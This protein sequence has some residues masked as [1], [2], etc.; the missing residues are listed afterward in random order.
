MHL[1]LSDTHIG[2]RRTDRHMDRLLEILAEHADPATTLVL[3]GDVFDFARNLSFGESHRRFM[4]AARGFRET[5]YIEGNHDW[6]VAGIKD[7][8][9]GL[10][11][12]HRL[13]LTTPGGRF[14]MLHGHQQDR[15]ARGMVGHMV[16]HINRAVQQ[17]TAMD[18]QRAL[19]RTMVCQWFHDRQE[20][21]LV[22]RS[23]WGDVVVAGHTHRPGVRKVDGRTYVNT[24]A[25]LERDHCHYLLVDDSGGFELL[26]AYR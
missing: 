20:I 4:A 12:C 3:N 7:A 8:L 5:I 13:R 2:D 17:L 22:R 9:P 26:P 1:V 19:Q 25:W 16:V 15:L 24:G 18:V 6:F 10:R 14:E 11:C 23:S 21:R